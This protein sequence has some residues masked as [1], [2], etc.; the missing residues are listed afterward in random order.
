MDD[1]YLL[2]IKCKFVHVIVLINNKMKQK[3]DDKSSIKAQPGSQRRLALP[4][5][6]TLYCVDKSE[7]LIR[8]YTK[9]LLT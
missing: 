9:L 7:A 2:F 4:S 6:R 3:I 8:V 5:H 1:R